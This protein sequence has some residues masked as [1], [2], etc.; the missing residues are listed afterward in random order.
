LKR[1]S[2]RFFLSCGLLFS[3]LLVG[4]VQSASLPLVQVNIAGAAFGEQVLPGALGYNYFFPTAEHLEQWRIRHVKV[5][6]FPIL[7]ER[8][9]PHLGGDFDPTYAALI[10]T[11]LTQVG[12]KGMS[13]ILDIHNYG[14]YRGK[15]L[16]SSEVPLTAYHDLWRR[17]ADR[18]HTRTGLHGYDLMNEPH[19]GADAGWPAAAQA[20]IQGI[21]SVDSTH[22]IYVEGRAWSSAAQW[23]T[24]N[25]DL[26]ALKDP[27]NRLIFSA[28]LYLDGNGSGTYQSGPGLLFDPMV[29]VNRAKPFVEWLKRNGR[30]GHIGEFGFPGDDPRWAASAL[31][32][33]N[34]LK[35]QCVPVAYWAAGSMWGSYPLSIEPVNGVNRPQWKSLAP[36]VTAGACTSRY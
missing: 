8:L 17:I 12:Q 27:A 26:L 23:P 34:Y 30:Q 9:Q 25:D 15:L 24:L 1:F 35:A 29:G 21:R 7:W 11:F 18:W 32:L 16:G 33:L 2:R 6:R 5:I 14:A 28:H 10:D 13:A 36:F 4:P 3:P 22:P 19:D 31:L 20:G